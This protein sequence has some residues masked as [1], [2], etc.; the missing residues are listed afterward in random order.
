MRSPAREQLINCA[1]HNGR[2]PAHRSLGICNTVWHFCTQHSGTEKG[3]H[4][5]ERELDGKKGAG[6]GGWD[7]AEERGL[8]ELQLKC[9]N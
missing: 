7:V 4:N 8:I 5:R 9:F 2:A 3:S 6:R 1:C